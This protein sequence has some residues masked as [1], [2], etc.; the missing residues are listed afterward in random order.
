MMKSAWLLAIA[1]H[2]EGH[3][4]ARNDAELRRQVT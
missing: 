3:H 2:A 4:L 1:R